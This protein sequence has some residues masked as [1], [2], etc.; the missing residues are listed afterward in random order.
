MDWPYHFF[1]SIPAA[2]YAWLNFD[3]LI[4]VIAFLAGWAV[5]ADHLID[6]LSYYK[7]IPTAREVLSCSYY[8]KTRTA[9]IIFHAYEYALALF[10]FL[11]SLWPIYLNYSIH[12]LLDTAY[13]RALHPKPGYSLVYRIFK[14]FKVIEKPEFV[15]ETIDLKSMDLFSKNF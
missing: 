1:V 10:V 15:R 5:D 3:P 4:A 13:N 9:T 8:A 14:K 11:P 12:L 7:R 2:I 6:A